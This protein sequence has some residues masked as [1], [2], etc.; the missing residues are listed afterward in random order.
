MYQDAKPLY[1]F[2]A[3]L[4]LIS[5]DGERFMGSLSPPNAEYRDGVSVSDGEFKPTR[6]EDEARPRSVQHQFYPN[7][8]NTEGRHEE[9]PQ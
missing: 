8:W 1:L 6:T 7:V 4:A 3:F 2:Y 5:P 9:E